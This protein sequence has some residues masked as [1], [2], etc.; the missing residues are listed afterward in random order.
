MK[1]EKLVTST[2]YSQAFEKF[3]PVF[4]VLLILIG[5]DLAWN[6]TRALS[7]L[8]GLLERW[9][10]AIGWLAAGFFAVAMLFTL[11]NSWLGM[12]WY[13]FMNLLFAENRLG[14]R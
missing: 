6:R 4:I 10:L 8:L 1:P 11:T 14:S 3:A 5:I 12:P 9:R 13:D 2:L 7:Y